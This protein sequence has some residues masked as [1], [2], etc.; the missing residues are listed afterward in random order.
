MIQ[1]NT[2]Q[3][4]RHYTTVLIV[5][6]ILLCA[7][8]I[9]LQRDN[10]LGIY[11][12][13]C[14]CGMQNAIAATYSGAIIRTTHV[15][16]MFTDLGVLLGQLLRGVK[17]DWRPLKLYTL[18]ISGF[19]CGGAVSGLLFWRMHYATLLIP[20]ATTASAAIAYRIFLM[21]AVP[22]GSSPVSDGLADRPAG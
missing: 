17:T 14:A 2:L 4:G 15:T 16:G 22:A 10:D 5:E 13:C 1:S 6:S 11:L 7:A 18:L 19:L 20:A 3:L 8:V 9:L 12:C 21:R